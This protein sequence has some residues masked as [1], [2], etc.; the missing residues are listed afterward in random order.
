ML[1]SYPLTP[2]LC[3][4]STRKRRNAISR[5]FTFADRTVVPEIPG[6]A[7]A[8]LGLVPARELIR[9]LEDD[10]GE[11]IKNL[12]YDNVR[13]FQDFNPVNSEMRQTLEDP[14]LRRQFVL[15]NNDSWRSQIFRRSLRRSS[16]PKP[17]RAGCI[18]NEGPGG[19]TASMLPGEPHRTTKNYSAL[20]DQVGKN[21]FGNDHRLEP[22]YLAA[23]ALYRLEYFFRNQ[24]LPPKYKPARYHILYASRLLLAGKKLPLPNA[25]EMEKFCNKLTDVFWDTNQ[26]ETIFKIAVKAVDAVAKGNFD[27]D[28]IRTQPFTEA[29]ALKC[30]K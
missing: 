27:R 9:L 17:N 14:N 5:E 22:Y 23:I 26:S 10:N 24:L 12:F 30:V 21:I 11:I 16:R 28:H 1:S 7:E 25:N 6:V 2:T 4:N 19:L 13:D 15:M 8:Y 3:R 20:L 18:K 29:L